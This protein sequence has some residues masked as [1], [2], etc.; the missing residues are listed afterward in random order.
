MYANLTEYLYIDNIPIAVI[1]MNQRHAIN[2]SLFSQEYGLH[3]KL[4][5]NMHLEAFS[6][7]KSVNKEIETCNHKNSCRS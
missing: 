4:N 3:V 1:W 7:H 5:I 2:L 6:D